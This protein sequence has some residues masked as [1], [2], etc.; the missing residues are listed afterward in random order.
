MR[1]GRPQARRRHR[2]EPPDRRGPRDGQP[3]DLRQ[4]RLRARDQRQGLREAPRTTRTSRS[5]TTPSQAHYPPGST[6]K[7]VAGTGALADNKI[8]PYTRVQTQPLPHAR[9]DEVLGVEPPRLGRC[10]IKCGFA[11]S[12][13]TFFFQLAG[14]L[15]IDRLGYWAKQYG[16]GAPTGIDLPGEVAGIVPTNEWKQEALGERDLPGRDLPG[17]HRPGLRRRDADPA[18]QRLRGARQRRQALPAAGRPRVV[19]P[20]GTVV[21]RVQARS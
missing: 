5:S 19:G 13:D 21:R 7:L 9:P 8:T 14:M 11:H 18:D 16:F 17:R 20:D 15:G 4:Q 2:H 3:A 12:S 6:Y 1:G 10:T